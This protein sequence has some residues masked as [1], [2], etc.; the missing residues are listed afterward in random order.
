MHSHNP[1]QQLNRQ[2]YKLTLRIV[3]LIMSL[4]LSSQHQCKLQY[5]KLAELIKLL[6]L[7]DKHFEVLQRNTVV[8]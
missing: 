5:M 3:F 4:N 8:L 2:M 1:D 7:L 6:E